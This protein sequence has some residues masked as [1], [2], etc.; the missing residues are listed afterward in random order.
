MSLVVVFVILEKQNQGQGY[1]NL[2][3]TTAE[4]VV[5]TTGFNSLRT[6]TC[7]YLFIF[8]KKHIFPKYVVF[9]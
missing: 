2:D 6:H 7:R 1:V 5:L 8:I 4:L 3:S 9:F